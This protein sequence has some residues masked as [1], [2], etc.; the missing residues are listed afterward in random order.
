MKQSRS[1]I[2]KA[3]IAA[4]VFVAMV[5]GPAVAQG[6]VTKDQCVA[7]NASGQELRRDH[8]LASARAEFRTC[9]DP[10]CP[11]IVRDDC[12]RRLEEL[13]AAQPS[14]VFD[15]KDGSGHDLTAVAV[16]VDGRA[17]TDKLDGSPLQ[18]DPGDHAFTFTTAGVA[19]LSQTF[20]LKE[21]E[22]ERRERIVLGMLPGVASSEGEAAP[23]PR[24]AP[25]APLRTIGFVAGGIGVAGLIVGAAF[26]LSAISKNNA[27]N[28]DG[29]C[30]ASGCDPTGTSLRNTALGDATASTVAFVAGGVLTAAGLVVVLVA[31]SA[32]RPAVGWIDVSP[33]VGSSSAGLSFRGA[34]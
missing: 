25:R 27:S 8:K 5:A 4:S 7:A 15:A 16:T 24:A 28:A 1:S 11:G 34:W 20:V 3:A 2:R 19:P 10:S 12:T 23:E 6:D 29:H 14:I 26:G 33:V 18:M 21:G 31:P 9:G 17:L 32:K 13:E 30:D 22:K